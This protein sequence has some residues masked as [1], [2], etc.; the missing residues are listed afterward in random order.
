MA[1]RLAMDKSLAIKNLHVAG[2]SERR[3]AETLEIS[4]GAVRRH[5]AADNP[6]STKAQTGSAQT[7]P[8]DSNSTKAQTGCSPALPTTEPPQ[9]ASQ[10][11]PFREL[12]LG[13]LEQGLHAKRI[14]QDLVAEH[15][16]SG[17]Y[18]S[19]YRYVKWL[20]KSSDLPFR[21]IEV[22]PGSQLQVDFGTG[23]KIRMADGTFRRTHVFRAVLSYS[24]K[25]YTESVLR[26]TT[27]DFIRVLENSFHHFGGVP[28]TVVFDNAKCAVTTADWYD[29]ELNPKIIEFCQHYGCAFIPT[30]PRTPRHKGK[31]ERGVDY[32]QENALRGREFDSLAQQNEHL[33]HWEKNVADTRIHG[34]TRKQVA[35]LF[36]SAEKAALGKLPFE[37]FPFYH[38]GKRKVSRDGHIAVKR[39]YY[40][41]PP[42]YLGCDVWVRYDSR[43][44]RILNSKMELIA[45]HV[46]SEPGRFSTLRAHLD[47]RKISSVEKGLEYFLK[48]TRHLGPA[49][50][51]WAEAVVEAR[52]VEACRV[53]Q[54]LLSLAKKYSSD[55][56]NA[57]CDKAWRSHALNYRTIKKLLESET[58][59]SQ[60][61]MEFMDS[62][63]IIR[64]VSEY[65]KFVH[66][67][68]QGNEHVR[69]VVAST[70][71]ASP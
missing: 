23:A 64:P 32:A 7:G 2:Y 51:R 38:E 55:S 1:N 17:K 35:A 30:R 13:M 69:T 67:S 48:K 53:L 29:P 3:I 28:Q 15:E 19:V 6:N 12:I 8:G 16:F 34:T 27:E 46:V 37:R 4:R 31:V 18:W 21:R 36:Q 47:S 25:G 40:S 26:Q 50:C 54:G 63:P 33:A 58:A 65:A 5:L 44:L 22:E 71:K 60:T 39:A 61:T 20:G 45:T 11:E 62:H 24:R 57:A 52:G 41:A 9:S 43:M 70:E 10:C 49:A 68:I 66:Q 42:E 56:I 14:H 59:D